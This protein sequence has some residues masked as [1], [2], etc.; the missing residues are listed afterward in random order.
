MVPSVHF[1]LCVLT[2][3][4]STLSGAALLKT[5]RL[6]VLKERF[7][8]FTFICMK[9]YLLSR[10]S[11]HLCAVLGIQI[12]KGQEMCISRSGFKES[13]HA[14]WPLVIIFA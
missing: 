5:G 1:H 9:L 3:R 14:F 11:L 12:P 6:L 13:E 2:D 7:P 8:I 10:L 4:I